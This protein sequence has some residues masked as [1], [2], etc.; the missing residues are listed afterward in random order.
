MV[1]KGEI[2]TTALRTAISGQ[3]ILFGHTRYFRSQI[4]PVLV[5]VATLAIFAAMSASLSYEAI[6][7]LIQNGFS[8]FQNIAPVS[9][10]NIGVRRL[11]V[12]LAAILATWLAFQYAVRQV[13]IVFASRTSWSR[14]VMSY[15]SRALASMPTPLLGATILPVFFTSEYLLTT[16]GPVY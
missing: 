4:M 5:Y 9:T 13:L 11:S 1:R 3:R 14:R 16:A 10:M 7:H 2:K 12:S 8:Y 6:S 15:L